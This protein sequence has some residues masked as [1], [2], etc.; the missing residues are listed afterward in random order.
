[1]SEDYFNYPTSLYLPVK[2]D[3]LRKIADPQGRVES[4]FALVPVEKVPDISVEDTNP[5]EQ[6]IKSGVAKKIRESLVQHDGNFHLLNRGI[7]LSVANA[8]YDNK[9]ERLR[10]DLDVRGVHGNVD[11]G[12]TQRVIRETVGSKEWELNR[13]S[14]IES[15]QEIFPQYVRY[16]ILTGLSPDL[17]VKLAETRNTSVQVKDFSLDNLAGKF[18]WIKEQL[19]E[20]EGVIAYKENEKKPV[21]VRDVIALFTL[22]NI[23]LYPNTGSQHPIQAYS[24]KVRPLELFDSKQETYRALSPILTDILSLYDYVRATMRDIYN[25]NGG[26]FLKWES[27]DQKSVMNFHFDKA[28]LQ[29]DHKIA[30]GMV[31]PLLGAFRFLVRE[32]DGVCVWKVDDVRK[33]YERFGERLIRTALEGVRTK[34]N[35]PTAAGKDGALWDQLYNQVKLAYFELREIDEEKSVSV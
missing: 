19:S 21:N 18:K 16:E 32:K 35:N 28:L 29:A 30:D 6:N 22:F 25:D 33:F 24:S 10:L 9:T 14:I 31:Y 4:F 5:R 7:T 23:G 12:H 2:P 17:L 3:H 15:G 11:G 34:G 13:Q 26:K 1:M 20:Y 8:A 27:I